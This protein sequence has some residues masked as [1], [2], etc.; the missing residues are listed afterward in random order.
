MNIP[1]LDQIDRELAQRHLLD[2][3]LQTKKNYKVNWHHRILCE[4]LDKFAKG[5]IPRL[6]VFMPPRHG[7]SELGS[8]RLPAFILGQNPDAEIIACSYSSS[9]AE[10][11]NRDVQRI[12]DTPEYKNIFPETSLNKKNVKTDAKGSYIRNSSEFE[13]VGK[14]GG[15]RC[16]GVGGP[17]TGTGADFAIIDDPIKNMEEANSERIR[18]NVWDWYTSTLYTRLEGD[19][20]ED[21]KESENEASILVILTRWHQDDL[22]GRLLEAA[23]NNPDADQWEILELPAIKQNEGNENDPREIGEALWPGKYPIKRLKKIKASVGSKV[24]SSLYQQEP[25]PGEG[26]IFQKSWLQYWTQLPDARPE[27]KLISCDLT[28]KDTKTADFVVMSVYAKYGAN[29]YLLDQIRERMDFVQTLATFKELVNKHDDAPV[30]LV[31]EKANGAALIAMLNQEI[32][33][34]VPVVPKESKS[35]RAHAVAPFYESKNVFYPHPTIAPWVLEHE[36]EMT[37]F[38]FGR[39]DDRVDAETQAMQRFYQGQADSWTEDVGSNYNESSTFIS[40]MDW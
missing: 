9:L 12:I 37:S 6:M 13:V 15:Y 19:I 40:N 24:W 27:L 38:P 32:P 31:E 30:K 34:I 1:S 25:T 5:E 20:E 35:A 4:K 2:F 36:A 28:F 18:E 10:K 29:V 23:K 16:A 21:G 39:N 26:A 22:A 11:M 8:R 3:T 17:V 7:K 14:E 33:G